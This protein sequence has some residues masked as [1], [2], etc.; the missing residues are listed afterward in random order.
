MARKIEALLRLMSDIQH[1]ENDTALSGK[2]SVHYAADE[3]SEQDLDLLYAAA[4]EP[5]TPDFLKEEKKH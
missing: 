4:K 3:I 5:Q 2:Q 1:F